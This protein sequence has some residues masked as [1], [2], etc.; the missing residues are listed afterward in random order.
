METVELELI[1]KITLPDIDILQLFR[2]EKTGMKSPTDKDKRRDERLKFEDTYL[3]V[4]AE[5]VWTQTPTNP[6]WN[7]EK[8][9][10]LY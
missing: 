4:I 2:D 9:I 5:T 1:T 6:A 8:L 10:S 3:Q 7:S